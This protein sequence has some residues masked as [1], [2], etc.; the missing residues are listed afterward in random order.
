MSSL[1]QLLNDQKNLLLDVA[2]PGAKVQSRLEE[3]ID[4]QSR[5]EVL[6]KMAG[7]QERLPFSDLWQ[8]DDH[9]N[10]GSLPTYKWRRRYIENQFQLI[11]ACAAKASFPAMVVAS[12]AKDQSVAA[13][14]N[15]GIRYCSCFISYSGSDEEFARHL[16]DRL[17]QAGVDVWFAPEDMQAGKKLHEQI[18]EAISASDRLLIVLSNGSLKSD[19]VTSEM[20][21]ARRQ[22][23][24]T[25]KR[26]LFPVCLVDFDTLREW[27]C[28]DA[29]AGQ[30]LA[31]EVREY[32]IPD[33]T[34]W[35]NPDTFERSFARL[36]T[37]LHA[38]DLRKARAK[39]IPD[40]HVNFD[41]ANS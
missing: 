8:W 23:R 12:D 32:F 3:F 20:R 7:I 26:K 15:P 39:H 36:L 10:G 17:E 27:E 33:F 34:D 30:D 41:A 2:S 28:F 6:L 31:A 1:T 25:G 40:P 24:K 21:W 13:T 29:D 35:N 9:W 38:T 18:G 16:H 37:D 4:R 19:W 22:E 5:I 14:A 11:L